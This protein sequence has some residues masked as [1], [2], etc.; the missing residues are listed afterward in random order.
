ML[1]TKRMRLPVDVILVGIRWYATYLTGMVI[2]V[3]AAFKICRK[4]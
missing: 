4:T 1:S 3:K 2:K